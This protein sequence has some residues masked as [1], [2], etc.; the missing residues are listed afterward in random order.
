MASALIIM[1]LIL[2]FKPVGDQV[3][4]YKKDTRYLV[5][6][7]GRQYGKST[8]GQLRDMRRVWPNPKGNHYTVYPV[9]SQA[10][11]QFRRFLTDYAGFY[12]EKNL[13]DLSVRLNPGGMIRFLGSDNYL[14]IKGDTLTSAR[15]DECGTTHEAVWSE[16][17]RPM[18][19]VNQG[20][21]DFFGTPKGKNW[22]Y[23]MAML[24]QSGDPD[25]SYH[26]APSNASP[27]FTDDEFQRIAASTA[28][29]VFEQ[30]YLA[31]FKDS[32]SEVFR[33]FQDCIKGELSAAIPGRMYVMGAD[34]AKYSDWTVLTVWD[35]E[36][37]HLVAFERF[38]QIDWSI[39]EQ[40]IEN[41]ARQYND[42]HIK[43]DATGVGDPVYERLHKRGLN[44]R[45][46]K[47]TA[48]VKNH[49][50]ENLVMMIEKREITYP[51][52]PELVQEFSIFGIEKTNSGNTRYTA[53]S[54]YHDDI[55]ISCALG[56]SGLGEAK[57]MTV[58]KM[59]WM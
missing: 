13:T 32:G 26:H 51:H 27:F 14:N 44:I 37:R 59:G 53:P 3:E 17:L 31:I 43:I 46:I 23:R 49:L 39:Q 55:V 18:L 24:A 7:I 34:L 30:E 21:C 15:I 5:A 10:K 35:V 1:A 11:V 50:I 29:A 48:A 28:T 47:F 12:C 19:A 25:Y 41:L 33:G 40:R 2:P 42:A 36:S 38:N 8:I 22:F 16:V 58:G 9:T 6:P 52:I 57:P 54:G 45:P 56:A 20:P 4:L